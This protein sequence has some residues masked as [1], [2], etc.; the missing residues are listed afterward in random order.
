MSCAGSRPARR[1]RGT[2]PGA[3]PAD[4]GRSRRRRAAASGRSRIGPA[5]GRRAGTTRG[6]ARRARRRPRCCRPSRC[7]PGPR[8]G[9]SHCTRA[10]SEL[11]SIDH[12]LDVGDP[13]HVAQDHLVVGQQARRQDRQRAVLVAGR[14]DRARQRHSAFDYEL[15]QWDRPRVCTSGFRCSLWRRS[16]SVA[17]VGSV[18]E[19]RRARRALS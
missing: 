6:S 17:G 16:V 2:R 7:R 10:P 18:E 9:P 3:G 8:C 14:H 11:S 1:A 13:R 5:A 19:I 12:R 4:G 15:L